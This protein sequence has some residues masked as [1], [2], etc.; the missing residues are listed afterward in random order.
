M[1]TINEIRNID[2]RN[3]DDLCKLAEMMGYGGKFGQLQCKNGAFVSSL[4]EM[5]NDN[6]A[7]MD[8]IH[9]FILNHLDAFVKAGNIEEDDGV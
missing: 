9:I 1:A 3:T 2:L 7:M 4:L 5:L 8:A 6:S